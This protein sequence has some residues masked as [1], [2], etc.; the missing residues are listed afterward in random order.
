MDVHLVLKRNTEE[1]RPERDP[2]FHTGKTQ[3]A[4][5]FATPKI[6]SPSFVPQQGPSLQRRATVNTNILSIDI[7]T[8]NGVYRSPPGSIAQQVDLLAGDACFCKG[9]EAVFK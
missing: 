1:N 9:C 2:N 3:R 5:H 6:Y 4:M 7:G 8:S